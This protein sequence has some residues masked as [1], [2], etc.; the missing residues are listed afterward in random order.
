VLI[1][2]LRMLVVFC[3]FD[4]ACCV[5]CVLCGVVLLVLCAVCV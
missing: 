4:G 2:M 5:C 3:L 1:V